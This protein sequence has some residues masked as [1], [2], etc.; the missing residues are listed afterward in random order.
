MTVPVY[1]LKTRKY[2]DACRREADYWGHEALAADKAGI[3]FAADMRRA[4]RIF[5]NRGPGLPQQQIYDPQA[6]KIMNGSLYDSIFTMIKNHCKS[7]KVLVLTCGAGGLCLELARQGHH[8]L[9]IDISAG[10]IQVARKYHRENPCRRNFGTLKYKIADLNQI[11]LPKSSFDAVLAWDGLHH[12]LLQERLM[13][14]IRISLKADGLFIFSDNTGMHWASRVLG[15]AL[16]LILP[17]YTGYGRKLKIALAGEKYIRQ[18]M[19]QRSPFEEINTRSILRFARNYFNIHSLHA[20]GGIGFRAAIAGD[21]RLVPSLKYPFLKI[22]KKIDD[23]SV[24]CGILK[25]DHVL[26]VAGK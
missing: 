1:K 20:H 21:M 2:R 8:V 18:E 15:G 16:Y 4:Q 24:H 13:Q 5:V 26:I 19:M 23:W 22:L 11:E 12:I 17:T 7:A 6:E 25:G 9:G 3:C 14:Q 10:A